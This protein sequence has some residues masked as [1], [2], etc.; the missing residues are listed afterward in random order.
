[1]L[2]LCGENA[3]ARPPPGVE[4]GEEKMNVAYLLKHEENV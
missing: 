3:M 4:Q 1:M 2:L